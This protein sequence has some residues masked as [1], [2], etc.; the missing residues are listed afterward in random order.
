[1][2]E[3][4]NKTHRNLQEQVEFLT[5]KVKEH[6]NQ[7][8]V[9]D[10]FGIKV[11]GQIETPP[12]EDAIPP[13]GT[14][15]YG[16]TYAVGLEPPYR[17][18]V[19]TR[20]DATHPSDYWLDIGQFTIQGEQ[21]A[22]GDS[23]VKVEL[24]TSNQL[25]LTLSDGRILTV[26]GNLRGD[27]GKSPA[28]SMSPVS[29]GVRISI[30]NP[31][32][33]ITSTTIYN[34]TD[35]QSIK[36]DKGDPGQFNIR[37]IFST[38]ADLDRIT[39]PAPGDTALVISAS[40]ITTYDLWVAVPDSRT[41]EIYWENA[42]PLASGTYITVDGLPTPTWDA[43]TKV[44][45]LTPTTG[46]QVYIQKPKTTEVVG[47]A[48]RPTIAPSD[49][50]QLVVRD[51][52]N[53]KN[54]GQIIVPITP[55]NDEHATSK[56]YVDANSA[57]YRHH[58]HIIIATEGSDSAGFTIILYNRDPNKTTNLYLDSFPITGSVSLSS[59]QH[60]ALEASINTSSQSFSIQYYDNNGMISNA[61]F[62][63]PTY[64]SITDTVTKI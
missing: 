51:I 20:A 10:A 36:G 19:W 38:S 23:I 14:Q 64:L 46:Y 31:N 50:Y 61:D 58:I 39:S 33:T 13:A 3:F 12:A 57:L 41:S 25:V 7:T 6:Y 11:I 21:G 28:I 54:S 49:K 5:E 24:D 17:L 32:G 48:L 63:Y 2:F 30:T 37:G 27:D 59:T 35:G 43:N 60:L 45:T 42:G 53:D 40:G 9:L 62:S 52:I 4:N 44:S 22:P 34:G 1:M 55:I 8:R 29:G 15:D 47:Q 26:P 16:A 56:S 18:F